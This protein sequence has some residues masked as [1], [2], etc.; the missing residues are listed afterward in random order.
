M[1]IGGMGP[2]FADES[3]PQANPVGPAL[4][5]P[6]ADVVAGSVTDAPGADV[7]AAPDGDLASL[8]ED[9]ALPGAV[10]GPD[11]DEPK[12]PSGRYCE[13]GNVARITKNLK[14]TM[15]VKY[16]TF[17]RNNKPYAV[18]FKFA[19]KKSGTTT[20]GTSVTVSGETKILFLGK[21]K[22]EVNANA[23]KSWTS[24]LGVEVGGKA[25]ARSTVYGDYGIMKE[26]VRAYKA[27]M[28]SNCEIGRK[29]EMTVWAP[30][31]EG[32]VLK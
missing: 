16:S 23:S 7:E 10:D 19:S 29:Q 4:T 17:V 32:W 11:L 6:G 20:I 25:K 8:P 31:R 30:Y 14:N 12:A 5:A 18:D 2:A 28:Y 22:A 9:L 15:A 27:Y 24:E 1:I 26:N 3:G 13:P 21:I